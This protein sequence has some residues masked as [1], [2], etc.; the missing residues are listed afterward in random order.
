MP[1]TPTYSPIEIAAEVQELA[2]K[3]RSAVH[4]LD[5]DDA[6]FDDISAAI[7]QRTGQV[8]PYDKE[9][10]AD[11]IENMDSGVPLDPASLTPAEFGIDDTSLYITDEIGGG[12][13]VFLGRDQDGIYATGGT[14]N[15]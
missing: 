4:E 2:E 15:G 10:M 13:L 6:I 9:D 3:Y 14:S 1:D 12:N 8:E 11:A 7:Q 5:E